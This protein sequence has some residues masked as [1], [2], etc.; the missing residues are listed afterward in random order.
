MDATDCVEQQVVAGE[1]DDAMFTDEKCV[2]KK[3]NKAKE[4]EKAERE[5]AYHSPSF[6]LH[7]HKLVACDSAVMHQYFV[8]RRY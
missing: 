4:K 7:P 6:R 2:R 3:K 8:R 1:G 5:I